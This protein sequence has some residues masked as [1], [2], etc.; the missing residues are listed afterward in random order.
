MS[1]MM[2]AATTPPTQYPTVIGQSFRGGIYDGLQSST[3]KPAVRYVRLV[4]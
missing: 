3:S 4:R 2:L 1:G